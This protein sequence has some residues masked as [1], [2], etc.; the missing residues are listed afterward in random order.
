MSQKD[1]SSA[2]LILNC[3]TAVL[4]TPL[5]REYPDLF[6]S[7]YNNIAHS[8]NLQGNVHMSIM[9]L[10]KALEC[11]LQ[12][13]DLELFVINKNEGERMPI[14]ETYINIA[15]AYAF[16]NNTQSALEYAEGAV[17]MSQR[18]ME[19]VTIRGSD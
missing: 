12:I 18:L 8:F 16:Q 19:L 15:N 1:Y 7:T 3:C 13:R 17:S 10:I 4:N 6:F 9:N 14:V 5:G 2:S 11:A